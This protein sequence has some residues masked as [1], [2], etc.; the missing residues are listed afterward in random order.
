M[1]FL[2][3]PYRYAAAGGGGGYT[4]FRLDMA[5]SV[6]GGF[7][8]LA[9]AGFLLTYNG[10]RQSSSDNFA[11][12]EP[13][14]ADL[15][16]DSNAATVWTNAT[17]DSA[18][19]EWGQQ[20]A[21]PIAAMAAY[22]RVASGTQYGPT[23]IVVKS[24]SDGSS[25]STAWTAVG[26]TEWRQFEI[27][28]FCNPAAL[29]TG[30]P[31]AFGNQDN[32]ASGGGQFY[33]TG[34]HHATF[35][36]NTAGVSVSVSEIDVL[37]ITSAGGDTQL[38]LYADS[39]GVPGALLGTSTLKTALGTGDQTFVFS[40]P[41]TVTAGTK[42]WVAI[43]STGNISA[44]AVANIGSRYKGSGS[45]FSNPFGGS[46]GWSSGVPARLRGVVA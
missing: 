26:T 9:E 20:F 12:S 24:S 43:R 28:R 6:N 45:T 10:S 23:A 37:G 44:S 27:R 17:L 35:Y 18:P 41:V 32:W 30:D 14:S 25:Y 22:V 39:A 1:G 5:S 36:Y 15:A 38:A 11:S 7:V 34:E 40:S 16:T 2:I 4:Y 3:N 42:I 33:W 8:E 13:V 29:T 46:S 21:S 31:I 19:W